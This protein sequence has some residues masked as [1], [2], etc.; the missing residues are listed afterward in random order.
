LFLM[1]PLHKISFESF[2]IKLPLI[3]FIEIN[4]MS[5]RQ[6][7]EKAL[8]RTGLAISRSR[9]SGVAQA[10]KLKACDPAHLRRTGLHPLGFDDV[11]SDRRIG[12]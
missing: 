6:S 5:D 11:I 1:S 7:Q 9:P 8:K 2:I 4:R 10:D 12:C 3:T